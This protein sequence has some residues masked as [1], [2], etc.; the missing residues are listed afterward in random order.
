MGTSP[1]SNAR[2]RGFGGKPSVRRGLVC[3]I[4]DAS[5]S[6]PSE[7]VY[8]FDQRNYLSQAPG[9]GE[10]DRCA[11]SA[12]VQQHAGQPGAAR[13][14]RIFIEAV[15]DMQ[16]LFGL[17]AVQSQ[18]RVEYLRRRLRVSDAARYHQRV[19]ARGDAE[20]VEGRQQGGIEIG[21]EIEDAPDQLFP[22]L[23]L[24]GIDLTGFGPWKGERGRG[25]K[26]ASKALTDLF[27]R[28]LHA[29]FLRQ[30]G[31]ALA[32]RSYGFDQRSR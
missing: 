23:P 31:V 10:G 32:D 27:G 2:L 12:P 28:R 5:Y 11:L 7:R 20:T 26:A 19:E 29:V 16:G 8:S 4:A 15:A 30:S 1:S 14:G 3:A 21:E 18:G 24:Q 25:G 13:P 6:R 9:P 17:E 22:P